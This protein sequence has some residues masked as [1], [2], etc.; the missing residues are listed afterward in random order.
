M[1]ISIVRSCNFIRAQQVELGYYAVLGKM[2]SDIIVR[3]PK[4]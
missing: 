4:S 1:P 2:H 3:Q